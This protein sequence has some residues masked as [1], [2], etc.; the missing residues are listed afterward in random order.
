MLQLFTVVYF[1]LFFH[2]NGYLPSPFLY[3]KANTFMDLFNT[4]FWASHTGRYEI[5]KSVYPPLV[6]IFLNSVKAILIP[7]MIYPNPNELR[8]GAYN[9]EIALVIVYFALPAL[10][11]SLQIWRGFNIREKLLIYV[12]AVSSIPFLFALERGNVILLATPLLTLLFGKSQRWRVLALAL[13]INIKP[14]FALLFLAYAVKKY[15]DELFIVVLATGTTYL[16]TATMLNVNFTSMLFNLVGFTQHS[17]FSLRD[18]LSFPNSVSA[19]STVL[20]NPRFIHSKYSI[21]WMNPLWIAEFINICKW[22]I[23]GW[24]FTEIF[25]ASKEIS[26]GV[27]F[28]LLIIIITNFGN[29]TGGYSLIFYFALIPA[30]KDM[31]Y[32]PLYFLIVAA[33]YLPLDPLFPLVHNNLG[34]QIS[35]LGGRAV[36][37]QWTFGLMTALRP[38]LNLLFLAVMAFE[39][40]RLRVPIQTRQIA[41]DGH[42]ILPFL[43]TNGNH[44]VN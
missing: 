42:H 13:L 31:R 17:I 40:S 21:H 3:N 14:Y 9:V 30:L 22:A 29:S 43:N 7:T 18:I 16:A 5:W 44:D 34:T 26:I 23:I 2:R 24:S 25:R 38:W 41:L 15:W 1:Y 11:L 28:T 6:F 37:V 36:D 19:F 27:S 39:L 20:S 4:M 10:A 12:T 35:F 33:I 32:A 8:A